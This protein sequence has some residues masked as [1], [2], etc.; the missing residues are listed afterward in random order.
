MRRFPFS[1]VVGMDDLKLALVLCAIDPAIGGVLARGDKG[2]AKTTL[3]R[4]LARLLPN[5]A[6]FVDLP[7]GASEDRLIGTLDLASV[8]GGNGVKFQ[9]GLLA[10]A[11][12]GVLYVDE[13]NLLA[14]H[15]VD[16]LLD[17]ATSGVNLIEREGISHQHPARFVLIGSMNPEEG[18]LRPQL[19]DRFGLSVEVTA[20]LDSGSRA[21]AVKR[22][23]AF[24]EDPVGFVGEWAAQE[25]A[26]RARLAQTEPATVTD[27]LLEGISRLCG[28]V[29]AQGLRADI[30]IARSAA[31][32]A[33][34]EGRITT[35][36]EDVRRI[37]PFALA[38]R[39]RL[40]PF[41]SHGFDEDQLEKALDEAFQRS[42][43]E[44]DRPDS[45]DIQSSSGGPSHISN[46]EENVMLGS[47]QAVMHVGT[48]RS[49][50]LLGDGRRSKALGDR[51]RFIDSRKPDGPITSMAV[52]PTLY[53]AATRQG[54]AGESSPTL[55]I[56]PGDIRQAVRETTTSNLVI[57]LLDTSSSMGLEKRIQ[58]ASSALAG[59][60]LDA[61]QRRDRVCVVGFRGDEAEVLC[62]PT[63]SIEVARARLA[64]LTT[65]GRT[66]L[67]SGLRS[68]LELAISASSDVRPL[69]IL[70]SDGRATSAPDGIE[71]IEAALAEARAIRRHNVDAVVIDAEEGPTRLG[72][73]SEIAS[74]MG[75]RLISLNE[76]MP[77]VMRE[78]LL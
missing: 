33:G 14:D 64:S 50:G 9:P 12:S 53:A 26:L 75:A 47:A 34:W 29:G 1:A 63:R 73:C 30:V 32:L 68:A 17:V 27:E 61:Y 4:G 40:C 69:V 7:I 31:A 21:E 62:R 48:T 60:L 5:E 23:L 36:F 6:S 35:T 10:K 22:R 16:V 54:R 37:A 66:P 55:V 52:A 76:F 59:V 71:P 67:A 13:V 49:A 72:L 65:G 19:L 70:I 3:A 51:G 45:Q 44:I 58:A 46:N 43:S 8:L 15:L 74:A 77:T 28:S 2:S 57:V 11:H 78:M 24:D 18:E 42:E 41:D 39:Q 20:S 38:H 25:E 56:E